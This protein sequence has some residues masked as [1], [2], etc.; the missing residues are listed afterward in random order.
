MA[1]YLLVLPCIAD[2]LTQ[3]TNGLEALAT[4]G[5][6]PTRIDSPA[7]QHREHNVL[8][9]NYKDGICEVN[10]L[11]HSITLCILGALIVPKARA[12]EWDKKTT[13][14]F[15]ESVPVPGTTLSAGTYVFKLADSSDRTIVQ[16]WNEDETRL[17]TTI[18]A[19]ADY[20]A[21]T[22]D[23][24]IV[25]FD[26]RPAGQPK[27]LRAWF[28][29][30]D[31]SGVEL[32]YPKQRATELAQANQQPVLSVPEDATDAASMKTATVEPVAPPR[33]TAADNPQELMEIAQVTAAE[34]EEL[35]HTA[36]A[37]P[38][39]AMGGLLLLAGAVGLRRLSLNSR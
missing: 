7:A 24:T 37:M 36:S 9:E 18:L 31:T 11:Q 25:S 30:G 12:D 26:E 19:V 13:L 1:W 16:I 2:A 17:I 39:I 28:Y 33:V 3:T 15:N 22:P 10:Q 35:P 8:Q 5:R 27:A 14:T 29:P 38:S 34:T 4:R 32:V 6:P 21:K 20:R 23:K